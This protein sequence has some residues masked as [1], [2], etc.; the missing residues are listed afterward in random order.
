MLSSQTSEHFTLQAS[1]LFGIYLEIL[2]TISKFVVNLQVGR[3]CLKV[4][5]IHVTL[6]QYFFLEDW[7]SQ[8]TCYLEQ[9]LV[10]LWYCWQYNITLGHLTYSHSVYSNLC[11]RGEFLSTVW[12]LFRDRLCF[13][14]SDLYMF[15]SVLISQGKMRC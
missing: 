14:V 15:G 12:W 1:I 13:N 2:A 4:Y 11:F 8:T 3:R 10:S 9:I 7:I 6:A 5:M